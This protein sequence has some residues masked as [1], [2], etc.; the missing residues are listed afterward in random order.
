MI[1]KYIICLAIVGGNVGKSERGDSEGPEE[2]RSAN[3]TADLE[4]VGAETEHSVVDIPAGDST[5]LQCS[6]E[7]VAIQQGKFPMQINLSCLVCLI[8]EGTHSLNREYQRLRF[9]QHCS[10]SQ[11]IP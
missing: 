2:Y 4:T 5:Q 7:T 9:T 8:F 1:P 3:E 6:S 11:S 10:Q